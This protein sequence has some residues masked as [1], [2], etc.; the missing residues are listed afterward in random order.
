[1]ATEPSAEPYFRIYGAYDRGGPVFYPREECPWLAEME[2]QGPVIRAELE[3]F[4]RSERV[5]LPIAYVPDDVR[6]EG[7]RSVNFVS[8][9]HWYRRSCEAFPRTV[10]FLETVPHLSTAFI[11][12]LEPGASL[13]V[14]NGDTDATYRCHLGLIV[15]S[16]SVEECGLGVGGERTGWREGAAF[17]FNEAYPHTVWNRTDRD[18]AILVLDVL[19]PPYRARG[20]RVCGQAL[21]A[22]TIT[23]LEA[24][25]PVLARAS[26]RVRR[27][28]HR[29]LG[30]AAQALITLRD[31]AARW[32]RVWRSQRSAPIA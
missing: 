12:L 1:M 18:R 26:N 5:S 21:A 19:R 22:M 7:W 8:Y 31:D 25:L 28:L 16:E 2:R 20:V 29:A 30:L 32:D 15:P 9:R 14:H 13:P 10:A 11:T 3:A 23:A 24:S 6:I 17:A 4:L 27:L